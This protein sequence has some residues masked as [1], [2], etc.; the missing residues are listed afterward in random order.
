MGGVGVN[1]S[2]SSAGG[3][4]QQQS[5]YL[6]PSDKRQLQQIS[7]SK[8][9]VSNVKP[10]LEVLAS[11]YDKGYAHNDAELCR[12]CQLVASKYV[13][14]AKQNKIIDDSLRNTAKK[15]GVYIP[16]ISKSLVLAA[17]N[18][19]F[20]YNPLHAVTKITSKATTK[21][22]S[23]VFGDEQ[24]ED[25]YAG[26]PIRTSEHEAP[27]PGGIQHL[28]LILGS[29]DS[30]KNIG[31]MIVVKPEN[32]DVIA[33]YSVEELSHDDAVQKGFLAFCAANYS[34]DG[35]RPATATIMNGDPR[36][37]YVDPKMNGI[38]VMKNGKPTILNSKDADIYD[39]MENALISK[40]TMFQ[41]NLLIRNGKNIVQAAGSSTDKEIRRLLVTFYDNSY[42]IVQINENVDLYEA[43]EILEKLPN[44]K[45]AVNF[46]TGGSNVAGYLRADGKPAENTGEKNTIIKVTSATMFYIKA[47]PGVQLAATQ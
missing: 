5:L 31:E 22:S 47:N 9:N 25:L 4:P 17:S 28:N 46:D 27:L 39:Q 45:D 15:L 44:I 42:G 41:S 20:N 2:D 35:T 24:H 38:V 3:I 37:L 11:I 7:N 19:F 34:I 29:G 18:V 13:L 30:E 36:N 43:G 23:A 14:F 21:I 6:D 12:Q 26:S 16:F 32:N 10:R 40:G 8:P 1:A 33:G